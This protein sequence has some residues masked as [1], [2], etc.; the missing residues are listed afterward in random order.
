MPNCVACLRCGQKFAAQTDPRKKN[1]PC[2]RCGSTE[3]LELV[4]VP[5]PEP[6][7]E[8]VA[9]SAAPPRPRPKPVA[10]PVPAA[11]NAAW[12]DKIDRPEE[13]SD[14]P[15]ETVGRPETSRSPRR[16]AGGILAA[17]ALV[18]VI[19]LAAWIGR[20]LLHG[21]DEP[22]VSRGVESPQSKPAPVESPLDVPGAIE[23]EQPE[24]EPLPPFEPPGPMEIAPGEN[25]AP[26]GPPMEAP[27]EPVASPPDEPL[28]P[29]PPAQDPSQAVEPPVEPGGAT[30]QPGGPQPIV[31]EAA[32]P[33]GVTPPAAEPPPESPTGTPTPPATEFAGSLEEAEAAM[34]KFELPLGIGDLA[35]H[36][37]GFLVDARGW[38]ATNHHIAASITTDARVKT[39]D[40]RLLA[41]EGVVARLPER[42]LALVK[43]ADPPDDLTLLDVGFDGTPARGEQVYAFGHPYQAEFSLSSGIVSRVL[44][45]QELV[46][47]SRQHLVTKIGAPLDMV[48]I[49]HDAKISPGNSGGPLLDKQGRVLGV[50]TFVNVPAE[51]GYASHVRYL[52]E[53]MAAATGPIEP[54]PPPQEFVCT[55]V[56]SERIRALFAAA[57]GFAWKPTTTEQYEQVAELAKQMTL[58]KHALLE[59]NSRPGAPWTLVQNAAQV[60][61]QAFAAMRQADWGVAQFTAFNAFSPAQS[62]QAWQGVVLDGVVWAPTRQQGVVVMAIHGTQKPLLVQLAGA[63][64]LPQGSRWLVLG[65]V[66][67]ATA[68]IRIDGRPE[69]EQAHVLLVH[70]MLPVR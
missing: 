23:P 63:A 59:A 37:A 14:I 30:P 26:Q 6:T 5:A 22:A 2:P 8:E 17:A 42:D 28:A 39:P 19:G 41:I 55:V 69:P 64:K 29:A 58:A 57:N 12:E 20:G 67:S 60:A 44:T 27:V 70:Y 38:I 36:G 16:L 11:D 51:F 35:Q 24:V 32:Q 13:A 34:V 65:L 9:A 49:Q 47:A 31:P 40:G 33:E 3:Q 66:T 10:K 61:D 18:A 21:P 56:S 15:T 68:Q 45:S 53:M 25:A 62:E 54:P 46:D 52:R 43:I 1:A 48:W 7:P 4:G 50:N